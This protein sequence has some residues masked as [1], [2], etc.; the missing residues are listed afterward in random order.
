LRQPTSRGPTADFR[1][2]DLAPLEPGIAPEWARLVRAPNPGPM[3]LDGTNTWVIGVAGSHGGQGTVVVDPGPLDEGHLAQVADVAGD[4]VSCVVLTH[5]HADHA[6]GAAELARSLGVSLRAVDP[7]F[8][9]DAEPFGIG[10]VVAASGA[11]VRVL[12]TPGHSADSVCFVLRASN[13]QQASAIMTGDTILGRG[14]TAIVAPDGRLGEYLESMRQLQTLDANLTV[15]PGHGPVLDD[16]HAVAAAYLAHRAER[17]AEI[18]AVIASG[19]D[20]VEGIVDTVYGDVDPRVRFAA[21]MS[22]Q[23]QLDYLRDRGSRTRNGS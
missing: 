10:E 12:H 3:T 4:S 15:L 13:E 22:V 7:S 6:A 21:Q 9:V 14:T 8:C 16:L 20:D 1:M 18:E 17:L 23:A 19:V 5:T 2:S 11:E